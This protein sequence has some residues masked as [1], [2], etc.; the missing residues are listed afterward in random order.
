MPSYGK[1]GGTGPTAGKKAQ[2]YT[3]T[4]KVT[5][6]AYRLKAFGFRA[7]G[8]V[9]LVLPQG[10]G[11]E[12]VYFEGQKKPWVF[13]MYKEDAEYWLAQ[14]AKGHPKACCVK[15]ELEAKSA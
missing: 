2:I 11:N 6:F 14:N 15:P 9:A 3:Y 5:G 12:P 7:E 10:E 8:E 4:D 1:K 13:L